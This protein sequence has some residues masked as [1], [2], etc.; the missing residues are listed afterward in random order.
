MHSVFYMLGLNDVR[1]IGSSGGG[2]DLDK[3]KVSL[4]LNCG[5]VRV[6]TGTEY[7]S[8]YEYPTIKCRL[9]D[10]MTDHRGMPAQYFWKEGFG[11]AT[12]PRWTGREVIG[13]LDEMGA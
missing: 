2:E 5:H 3:Y 9:C 4:K 7:E 10:R 12:D 6:I 11:P 1:V 8:F 13:G